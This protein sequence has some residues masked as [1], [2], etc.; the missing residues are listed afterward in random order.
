MLCTAGNYR[1]VR[2]GA[3]LFNRLTQGLGKE[4]RDRCW[5]QQEIAGGGWELLLAALEL[6][7]GLGMRS[8][9]VKAA[10]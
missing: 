8:C 7:Q 1:E 2:G 5:A 4:E 10:G 3:E 9:R 6:T